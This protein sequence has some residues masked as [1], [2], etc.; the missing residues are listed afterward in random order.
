MVSSQNKQLHVERLKAGI[1][2]MKVFVN[3]TSFTN[4]IIV[5]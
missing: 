5:K 2:I 4:Q 3:E 1:Y